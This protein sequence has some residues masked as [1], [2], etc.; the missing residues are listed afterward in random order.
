MTLHWQKAF[1]HKGRTFEVRVETHDEPSYLEATVFEDG[2][3]ADVIYPGGAEG[4][5][6]YGATF[7]RDA[8]PE[9]KLAAEDLMALAEADFRRRL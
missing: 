9:L 5:P 4:M 7:D 6:V 8:G 2:S 1:S 3:P